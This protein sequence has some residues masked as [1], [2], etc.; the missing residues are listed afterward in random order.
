M[1]NIKNT[2]TTINSNDNQPGVIYVGRTEA[3]TLFLGKV[4]MVASPEFLEGR[5]WSYRVADRP[6]SF[7]L[8]AA[9]AVEVPEN[10]S[11]GPLRHTSI[12]RSR[13]R[14]CFGLERTSR[15]RDAT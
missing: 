14:A 15:R 13:T 2:P 1:A 8:D 6:F 7:V 10:S 4:G 3:E 9:Y 11:I 12:A 5:V